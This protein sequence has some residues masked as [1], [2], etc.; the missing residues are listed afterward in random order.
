MEDC[1]AVCSPGNAEEKEDDVARLKRI[2]DEQLKELEAIE[3]ELLH[4]QAEEETPEGVEE[5]LGNK[6]MAKDVLLD[7]LMVDIE[8]Q[9]GFGA[10]KPTKVE[11]KKNHHSRIRASQFNTNPLM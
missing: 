1:R 2:R 4:R 10:D 5:K 7:S 9:V 8:D 11:M 6:Y 3:Q